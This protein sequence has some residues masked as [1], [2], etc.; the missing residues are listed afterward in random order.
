[1]NSNYS[2]LLISYVTNPRNEIYLFIDNNSILIL[3]FQ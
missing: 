3:F 1:M 2:I